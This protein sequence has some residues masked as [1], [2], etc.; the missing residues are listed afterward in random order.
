MSGK[1]MIVK[2]I[3]LALLITLFSS[4]FSCSYADGVNGPFEDFMKRASYGFTI[5]NPRI[6][7]AETYDEF[8]AGDAT[9]L[10]IDF[11]TA[12]V[13]L[14]IYEITEKN[15]SEAYSLANKIFNS[16]DHGVEFQ[17][18]VAGTDSETNHINFLFGVQESEKSDYEIIWLDYEIATHRL[19]GGSNSWS[20]EMGATMYQLEIS[21]LAQ[22]YPNTRYESFG[23]VN[24]GELPG[25]MADFLR[26]ALEMGEKK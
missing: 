11:I 8:E 9:Q 14:Y 18:L 4:F 20:P 2:L 5:K 19:H 25:I 16:E 7:L 6:A 22:K 15:V 12:W 1:K 24:V 13:D 10:L 3:T 21:S 26:V 23:G 17:V